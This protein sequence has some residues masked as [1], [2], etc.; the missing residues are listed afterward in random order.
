MGIAPQKRL[1][2]ARFQYR[3]TTKFRMPQKHV[4]VLDMLLGYVQKPSLFGHILKICSFREHVSCLAYLILPGIASPRSPTIASLPQDNRIHQHAL[5]RNQI[6]PPF[7]SASALFV[8]IVFLSTIFVSSPAFAACGGRSWG[9][10]TPKT[11]RCHRI[12]NAA[13]YNTIRQIYAV[14]TLCSP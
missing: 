13:N 4:H 6:P 1:Y 11:S 9:R 5:I 10:P 3:A 7:G 14:L 12:N 2:L 8:A